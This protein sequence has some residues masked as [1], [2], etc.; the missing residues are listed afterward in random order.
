MQTQSAAQPAAERTVLS[1]S[2][3]AQLFHASLRLA[4]LILPVDGFASS[5]G[6]N[7]VA[8]KPAQSPGKQEY[9]A[10]SGMKAMLKNTGVGVLKTMPTSRI[11]LK[12]TQYHPMP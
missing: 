1:M 7:S 2:R 12:L 6:R 10:I 3:M 9:T 11:Q 4:G 8:A 5:P